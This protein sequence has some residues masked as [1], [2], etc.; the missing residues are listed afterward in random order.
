MKK[1]VKNK[2]LKKVSKKVSSGTNKSEKLLLENFVALQKVNTNLMIKLDNLSNQISNLLKIFENSAKALIEKDLDIGNKKVHEK[3]EKV[4]EQ[5]KIIA[6]GVSLVHDKLE[7]THFTEY[8]QEENQNPIQ[9]LQESNQELMH[10]PEQN[11]YSQEMPSEPTQQNF[12]QEIN[13]P[14]LPQLPPITPES[15][16]NMQQINQQPAQ[17]QQPIQQNKT[18]NDQQN[19]Y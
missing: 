5:D 16:G 17:F 12:Q 9:E 15:Q 1:R 4:L 13:P 11:Q 6:K 18:N 3:L 19:K 14:K 10:S 2:S 7:E 8:S